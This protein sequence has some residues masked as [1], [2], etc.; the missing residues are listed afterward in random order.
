MR[1]GRGGRV[2]LLRRG[3]NGDNALVHQL[4]IPGFEEAQ[5]GVEGSE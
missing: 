5:T 3:R 2:G 4:C 1:S